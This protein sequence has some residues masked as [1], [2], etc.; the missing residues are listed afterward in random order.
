MDRI[1]VRRGRELIVLHESEILCFTSRDHFTCVITK[2]A[3]HR[4][5]LSLNRLEAH[6]DPKVF[7]RLHRNTLVRESAVRSA[8]GGP[9]MRVR[10]VNGLELSVSRANR[11]AV[12]ERALTTM[13]RGRP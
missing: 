2:D 8:Q 6:L 13:A 11:G 5:E 7:K 4:I 12:R 1:T 9:R 3:E 10:L